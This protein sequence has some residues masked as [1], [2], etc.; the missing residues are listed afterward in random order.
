MTDGNKSNNG[1]SHNALTFF[2]LNHLLKRG[3]ILFK[4]VLYG[5]WVKNYL[6]AQDKY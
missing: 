5:Y 6:V 1:F 2:Q 3:I 4:W